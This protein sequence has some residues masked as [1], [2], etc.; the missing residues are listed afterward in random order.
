MR[1]GNLR[2]NKCRANYKSFS[3]TSLDEINIDYAKWLLLIKLFGLGVSARKAAAESD[4]IYPTTLHTFD[5]M[6]LSILESQ[7]RTDDALNGQIEVDEAFL[8]AKGREAADAVPKTRRS[9]LASLREI[10]VSKSRQ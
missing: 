4:V 6:W 3:G 10:T 9:S 5:V 8:M 1:R 7:A 2:Y